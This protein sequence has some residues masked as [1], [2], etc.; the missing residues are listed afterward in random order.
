MA[1]AIRARYRETERVANREKK[2]YAEGQTG[3]GNRIN[4]R[5]RAALSKNGVENVSTRAI[6]AEA[7]GV[8]TDV[9]LYRLFGNKENL[10][11]RTFLREDE[12]LVDE[13]MKRSDV[14]WESSLPSGTGSGI[15]GIRSGCGSRSRTRK[16]VCFSTGTTIAR[17]AGN[18]RNRGISRFAR[19]LRKNGRRSFRA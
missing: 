8:G 1:N 11:L 2:T 3:A 18:R 4:G 12:K 17:F 9:Y 5:G 13:V 10:L 15:S 16:P 6:I 7:E 14:L 19:R